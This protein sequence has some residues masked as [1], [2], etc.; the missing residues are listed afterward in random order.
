VCLNHPR[1]ASRSPSVQLFPTNRD[2]PRHQIGFVRSKSLFLALIST[3]RPP[4][5]TIRLAS[6][7]QNRPFARAP[8]VPRRVENWL[9]SSY[10]P[11][12]HRR[13]CRRMITCRGASKARNADKCRRGS[14]ESLDTGS[15]H[16]GAR[17]KIGHFHGAGSQPAPSLQRPL[18]PPRGAR[19]SVLVRASPR[20]WSWYIF[21]NAEPAER[22]FR[23]RFCMSARA[24]DTSAATV[25]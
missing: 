21:C 12:L 9:R 18:M 8:V 19:L 2:R 17:P 10:F 20:T 3:R 4:L 7:A 6:F 13:Q 1:K 24:D 22:R 5:L 11:T 16:R 14:I 25:K 23:S 15:G